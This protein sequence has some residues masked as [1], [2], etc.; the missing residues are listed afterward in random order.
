[1]VKLGVFLADFILSFGFISRRL[2]LFTSINRSEWS[3][4]G[5]Y[6]SFKF[7]IFKLGVT[8][9]GILFHEC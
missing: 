8:G 1:M 2:R 4:F 3:S 7:Q 5:E 9:S 6:K